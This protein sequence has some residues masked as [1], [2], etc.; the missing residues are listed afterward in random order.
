MPITMQAGVKNVG[1][2]GE[3]ISKPARRSSAANKSKVASGN[4][5]SIK[6]LAL[7]DETN[8][9][10]RECTKVVGNNCGIQCD[11]CRGWVHQKCSDLDSSQY[12][13]LSQL[14]NP[15]V[16]WVC[17][18]CHKQSKQDNDP[19]DRLAANEAKIDTL[20]LLIHTLQT[21]NT[22]LQTQNTAII[23]MLEK[24]DN[25]M[26]EKVSEHV[27]ESVEEERERESRRNNIIV[28]NLRESAGGEKEERS[29]DDQKKLDDL[30]KDIGTDLT[31]QNL[32][33]SI[34]ETKRLG[35]Y[36]EGRDRPLKVIFADTEHKIKIL[37]KAKNLKESRKFSKI[38]ISS[39]KTL[40][41]RKED[42]RLRKELGERRKGGEDVIIYR[43]KV[44]QRET[45]N[46][47]GR[48]EDPNNGSQAAKGSG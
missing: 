10:C 2:D 6:H 45:I 21:Q 34:L 35:K 48:K 17:P 43:G 14:P 33:A 41:E 8:S 32:S 27:R 12:S 28:F 29:A 5:G 38:G 18:T 36:T 24:L 9:P 46:R 13:M 31:G 7:D 42:E 30:F 26:E 16:R 4:G 1:A 47:N 23:K 39:D 22:T 3:F 11:R 40:K 37:K 15:S 44:V 19:N 25:R 20:M